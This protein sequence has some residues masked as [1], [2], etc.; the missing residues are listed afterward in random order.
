M[1]LIPGLKKAPNKNR[2]FFHTSEYHQDVWKNVEFE[3]GAFVKPG[4][5]LIVFY[6]FSNFVSLVHKNINFE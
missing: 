3:F 5:K 2:T 1:S 6:A 4:I